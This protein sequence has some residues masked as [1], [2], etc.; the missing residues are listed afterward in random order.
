MKL[1]PDYPFCVALI[2]VI[3]VQVR[4]IFNIFITIEKILVIYYQ[5]I[6]GSKFF[7]PSR[8]LPKQY[9]YLYDL[10]EDLESGIEFVR[11][12]LLFYVS[13]SRMTVLFV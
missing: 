1:K 6:R 3:G 2:I 8:F 7:I 5:S 4:K 9:D 11:I 13:F 12:S 10:P